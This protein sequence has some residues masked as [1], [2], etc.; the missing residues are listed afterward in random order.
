MW[1]G[2]WSQPFQD[3]RQATIN[4]NLLFRR[5]QFGAD[6]LTQPKLLESAS[7]YLQATPIS[8]RFPPDIISYSVGLYYHFNLSHRD[9]EDFLAQRGITV[10]RQSIHLWCIEFGALY[11]RRLKHKHRGSGDDQGERARDA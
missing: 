3:P 5:P 4:C 6:M 8:I 9:I 11:A 7:E 10:T 2:N 1:I